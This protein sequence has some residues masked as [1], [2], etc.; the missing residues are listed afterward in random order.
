M[1][2]QGI[3][4]KKSLLSLKLFYII[5]LLSLKLSLTSSNKKPFQI[6]P[7]LT[8]YSSLLLLLRLLQ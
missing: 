5:L 8:N 6:V 7:F 1:M 4:E 3:T 2:V